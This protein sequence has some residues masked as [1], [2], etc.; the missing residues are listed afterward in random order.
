[1]HE[2]SHSIW[3]INQSAA[4][5]SQG[6]VSQKN[7]DENVKLLV[8]NILEKSTNL[9]N[10]LSNRSSEG[11]KHQ[12]QLSCRDGVIEAFRNAAAHLITSFGS[13]LELDFQIVPSEEVVSSFDSCLLLNLS[14]FDIVCAVARSQE[15][16][17]YPRVTATLEEGSTLS[18]SFPDARNSKDL[19]AVLSCYDSI[20]PGHVLTL[21]ESSLKVSIPLGA[22]LHQ[23]SSAIG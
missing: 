15:A 18:L 20:Y 8:A 2:I 21:S 3:V 6:V 22:Y 7:A 13:S 11:H 10:L 23:T 4:L 1:M 12:K 17:L 16:Q 14:V 5:L 19:D 9:Q